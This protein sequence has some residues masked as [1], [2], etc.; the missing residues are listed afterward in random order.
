M[1]IDLRR[2]KILCEEATSGPWRVGEPHEGVAYVGTAC[3]RPDIEGYNFS[4]RTKDAKF[5]AASHDAIPRL[6][7][8]NE[9]LKIILEEVAR[10]IK[11]LRPALAKKIIHILKEVECQN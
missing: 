5:I 11:P 2:L 7:K 4:V 3:D 10:G 1:S 9:R 6:I 8:E